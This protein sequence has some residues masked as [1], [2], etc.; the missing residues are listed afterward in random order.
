MQAIPTLTHAF[1]HLPA[2]VLDTVLDGRVDLGVLG[3]DSEDA[4]EPHPEDSTGTAGND[5]G[6]DTNDRSGAYGAGKGRDQRTKLRDVTFAFVIPLHGELDG[7]RQLALYE[8][9]ANREKDMRPE[10]EAYH[11]GTPDE[12]VYLIEERRNVH[13]IVKFP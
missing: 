3:R 5:S 7:E 8:P 13:D 1:E 9:R 6:C 2:M 10:E 11:G 4:R 12:G